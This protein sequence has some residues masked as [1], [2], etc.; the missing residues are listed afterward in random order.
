MD[1]DSDD[2]LR[3]PGTPSENDLPPPG[4]EAERQAKQPVMP[5]VWIPLGLIIVLIFVAILVFYHHT[6]H[7]IPFHG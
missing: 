3:R 5:V 4:A 1:T 2:P 7:V 6:G